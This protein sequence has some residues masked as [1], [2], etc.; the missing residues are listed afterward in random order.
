MGTLRELI[1]ASARGTFHSVAGALAVV[2]VA[3]GWANDVQAAAIVAAIVAVV[4]LG[5]AMLHATSTVRA[6]IYPVLAA[7]AAVAINYGIA[8][9]HQLLAVLG[10]AAAALGA[11]VAANYTPSGEA[12]AVGAH[13]VSN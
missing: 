4:D 1:P 12:K 2:L 3:Y 5:L 8:D 6:L 10:V 7:F 13:A 11:G 9:E